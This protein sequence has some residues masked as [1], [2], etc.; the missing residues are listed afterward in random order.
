MQRLKGLNN[1]ELDNG[2]MNNKVI[3]IYSNL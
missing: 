1:I 3:C 2:Y